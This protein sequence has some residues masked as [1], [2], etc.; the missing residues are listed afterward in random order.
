MP[1]A[2][3]LGVRLSGGGS[4]P[5]FTVRA[6]R[7]DAEVAL[8]A[9]FALPAPVLSG[10]TATYPEVLAG[11]DLVVRVGAESVSEVLVV[12][13]AEAAQQS[14]LSA[15]RFATRT[16]DASLR[17]SSSGGVELVDT[18]GNVVL[19]SPQPMMWDSSGTPDEVA[20]SGEATSVVSGSFLGASLARSALS[21]DAGTLSLS[22]RAVS[23]AGSAEPVVAGDASAEF[24]ET[25]AESVVEG[26]V[27]PDE[28]DVV[29]G[30][31]V[32]VTTSALTLVPDR[33]L[34]RGEDTVYPLFI[35][36][37]FAPK[38]SLW[39]YVNKTYPNEEYG[40]FDDSNGQGAGYSTWDGV[41][42]KRIFYMFRTSSMNGKVVE[43]ATLNAWAT[44]SYSCTPGTTAVHRTGDIS[45]ATNWNNQPKSYGVVDTA[46]TTRRTGCGNGKEPG[47]VT[48]TVTKAVRTTTG[49]GR[50][51]TTLSLRAGSESDITDWKRFRH[52]AKLSI[53]Y[54]TPVKTPTKLTMTDPETDC[55]EPVDDRPR[56]SAADPPTL[57][58]RVSDADGS[59]GQNLGAEF[60]L[61]KWN[62]T[63]QE[64]RFAY[65]LVTADKDVKPNDYGD[66]SWNTESVRADRTLPEGSWRWRVRGYDPFTKSAWAGA[67]SAMRWCF[68]RTDA[69]PPSKPPTVTAA[70]DNVYEV[71]RTISLTLGNNGIS[72][73]AS[74]QWSL[75]GGTWTGT[76][77][78][79]SLA[80]TH[81]GPNQL[82][83]RSVDQAG[84][85]SVATALTVGEAPGLFLVGGQALPRDRWKLDE[86]S[87]TTAADM[88]PT[89]QNYSDPW[90]TVTANALTLT[91]GR[92]GGRATWTTS[93][94]GSTC[95]SSTG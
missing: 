50:T 86:G 9:P 43:K 95:W 90:T 38:R 57:R 20:V 35:D 77:P 94:P 89:T 65:R 62:A 19:D 37:A 66:F 54:N 88:R 55:S 64:Y 10:S 27:G 87:G 71:G 73:V 93:T 52:T 8:V 82:R 16:S 11:V 40:K 92:P 36:P 31:G 61:Y 42:T 23:E 32:E 17:E 14:A 25:S 41:N 2:V 28:G 48:F 6:P 7:G 56:I 13:S 49:A 85:K 21:Q 3:A 84:N 67:S 18:L 79:L 5:L 74:Y 26:A 59:D 78:A 76:G 30:M 70:E 91:G 1:R 44:H 53:T 12:K 75:N 51:Y 68:F 29:A 24:A 47:W 33:E 72:D 46:T 80:L 81:F 60:E 39:T 83:L 22:T 69:T 63:A 34:L 4:A 58:A 45:S 15:L